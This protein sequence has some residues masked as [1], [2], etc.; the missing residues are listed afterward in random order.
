MHNKKTKIQQHINNPKKAKTI[1]YIRKYIKCYIVGLIYELQKRV[2]MAA[3][4]TSATSLVSRT[5]CEAFP[6][7]G[8]HFLSNKKRF[9]S[10]FVVPKAGREKMTIRY[11]A[12]NLSFTSFP[13]PP[14]AEPEVQ[15]RHPP[16]S[17]RASALLQN[18]K[19]TSRKHTPVCPPTIILQQNNY[20]EL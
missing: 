18:P 8:F 5:M 15:L 4:V 20:M 1:T 13:S 16:R 17:P 11:P 9:C 12:S 19:F 14:L 3:H 7:W 2:D 10:K 6:L